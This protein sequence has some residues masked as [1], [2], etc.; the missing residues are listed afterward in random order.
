LAARDFAKAPEIWVARTTNEMPTRARMG[1]LLDEIEDFARQ[2]LIK[3]F[4]DLR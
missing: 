3:I 4:E 2:L 1:Y